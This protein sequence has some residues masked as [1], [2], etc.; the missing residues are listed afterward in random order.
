MSNFFDIADE[1]EEDT[2]SWL[3]RVLKPLVKWVNFAFVTITFFEWLV[4]VIVLQR[5]GQLGKLALSIK[6]SLVIYPI[7]NVLRL[8]SLLLKHER[9]DNESQP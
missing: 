3:N 8:T 2:L 9:P 7:T 6:A 5:R 1:H 4:V